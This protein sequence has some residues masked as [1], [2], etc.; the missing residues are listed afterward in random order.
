VV[1]KRRTTRLSGLT[2][3]FITHGIAGRDAFV[4]VLPADFSPGDIFVPRG[5]RIRRIA[6]EA[7]PRSHPGSELHMTTI[8]CDQ[9]VLLNGL[10]KL[11]LRWLFIGDEIGAITGGNGDF[12]NVGGEGDVVRPR[13]A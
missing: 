1:A 2:I 8:T 6:L 11:L 10:G 5:Q 7:D 9:S 3:T 12:K 13:R 4:D